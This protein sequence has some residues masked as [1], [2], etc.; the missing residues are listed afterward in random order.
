VSSGWTTSNSP[1][2]GAKPLTT[3]KLSNLDTGEFQTIVSGLDPRNPA[4]YGVMD[5]QPQ[6]SS[7]ANFETT[8]HAYNWSL[9]IAAGIVLLLGGIGYWVYRKN[10]KSE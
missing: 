4:S 5:D 9:I 3:V 7:P 10:R 8:I 6:G 1:L 2:T